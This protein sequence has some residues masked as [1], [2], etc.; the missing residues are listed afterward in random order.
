MKTKYDQLKRIHNQAVA[1]KN[2]NVLRE[3][4][5][6]L[7]SWGTRCRA[8]D[9]Q[10]LW[11]NLSVPTS[12]AATITIGLRYQKR[13]DSLTED[14]FEL[15]KSDPDTVHPFYKGKYQGVRPEYAGTHKLQNV[16]AQSFT[17]VNTCCLF[18]GGKNGS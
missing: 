3:V 1:D 2:A 4:P 17:S 14:I 18:L 7:S 13:D 15:R 11:T 16:L 8:D 9:G 5:A 12:V 6:L 10:L